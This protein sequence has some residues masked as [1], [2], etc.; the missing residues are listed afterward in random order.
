[1]N[2]TNIFTYGLAQIFGLFLFVFAVAIFSR[3]D[4][5]RKIILNI[6]EDNPII[7][8]TATIGLLFGIILIGIHGGVLLHFR[9]YI[10]VICWLIFINSL[11]WLMIPEKMLEMTKRVFNGRGFYILMF[12]LVFFG[13]MLFFRASE[14]FIIRFG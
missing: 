4:Y 7:M 12:L 11:F 10:T 6:K 14:L 1:M 3:R 9:S 8:L 5:Y 2:V 13:F